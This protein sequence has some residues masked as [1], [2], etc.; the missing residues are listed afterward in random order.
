MV[1]PKGR[2][3]GEIDLETMVQELQDRGIGLPLLVRFSELVESRLAEI[4]GAFRTAIAEAGYTG[5]YQGVYPI[6]VN[7]DRHLVERLVSYG[8]QY[9]FGLEAGSKP[10]LLAVI[11]L[12]EDP[13]ALIVCNGYKDEEYVEI[14]LLASK[15]GR[16]TV[17]VVEKPAELPLIA[18]VAERTG[19]RP[20]LGLRARLS[21][22]GSGHWHESGGVRSKFGLSGRELVV[23]TEFLAERGLLEACELLHFHIG[24]QLGDIRAV[25]DAIRE[26]AWVYV[27]LSQLGAGLR[28]LDVGGGLGIDYD[29]TQTER[30]SSTNYTLQEYANDVVWGVQ[31]ICR[32]AGIPMPTLVTE[33][34][35]ATVAH[36]AALILDVLG[37]AALQEDEEPSE[38]PAD[39][40]TAVRLLWNTYQGANEGDALEVYHDAVAYRDQCLNLFRLGKLTLGQRAVV[41][42]LYRAILRRLR[43]VLTATEDAPD[44]LEELENALAETY[45]CNFSMF[46]SLPDAW[47]IDQLF[48]VVPL[49]R[50]DRRPTDRAVLADITCDSDGSLSQFIGWDGPERSLPLHPWNGEPYHLGVFLVGAY[51]ESLGDLHNLFGDTNT[52]V[53]S[54]D[55]EGGY[56]VDEVAVGDTVG[57]VLE[58]V[59][60]DRRDLVSRVRLATE[61]A[62]RQGDMK[63]SETRDL[64]RIYEEGLAGYTYL[65]GE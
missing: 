64:L 8:G 47:A 1:R 6:K 41:E 40:E 29:G 56:H 20:R 53:V 12:L 46:Q 42:Q 17:L 62:L 3:G 33:S 14:A 30:A 48:P 63:H 4:H 10:E 21:S 49:H 54:L 9:H 57:E 11:A 51:Q 55:P 45:F 52:V 25:K 35:R 26:A 2:E 36:H 16:R 15:L 7:Q 39:T 32:P 31:E 61:R 44:E 43:R 13:E 34:G 24:S 59:H 5:R 23:A 37:T 38:P 22:R 60:Y 19:L 18:K 50:L 27:N 28:Y 58:Y 65:E